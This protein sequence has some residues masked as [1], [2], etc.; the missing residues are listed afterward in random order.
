MSSLPLTARRAGRPHTSMFLRML[1]RAA[2]RRRGRAASALLAMVVA[3]AVA[4]AMLNL[5][6]DVQNKLQKEFRSYGANIVV[7]AKEGQ[8]LSPDALQ[9]VNAT[10]AD[11]GSAVPFGYVVARTASGQPVVVAGTD[12]V[13]A[14]KL[15]SWWKVSRWPET[16]QQGLLGVRAQTAV[17][18]QAFD[19]SFQGHTI[20]ITPA[21]VLQTGA[22]EDSRVYISL[23]DFENWT[24]IQPSTI[25]VAASGSAK[26]TEGVLQKLAAALPSVDV[27]AVRRI[28]EGEAQVMGKTR[29][30]LLSSAVLIVW[31]SALCVLATLIGWVVDRRR[32]FAIMKALGAS[33]R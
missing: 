2:V 30:T 29:A 26:E 23:A 8:A 32:D 1:L 28:V 11:R 16:P 22:D 10:V 17:G 31:T 14:R 3:A 15:N 25:E 18:S 6:G 5:Y 7:V 20:H 13:Q 21:G 19:L 4:T 27:H 24:G 33:E 12:F 9:I